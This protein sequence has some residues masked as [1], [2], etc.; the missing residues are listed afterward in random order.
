MNLSDD[1]RKSD[2]LLAHLCAK[3]MEPVTTEHPPVFTVEEARELRGQIDGVHTKNLFLRDAKRNYFLYVTDEDAIV[4]LQALAW[5]IGARGR[6]SFGSREALLELLGVQPGSVSLLAA[7]N[8]TAV[9]VTVVLDERILSGLVINCH[10]LTN[11]RT[12]SLS[13]E[14]AIAFLRSSGH[15]PIVVSLGADRAATQS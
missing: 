5:K 15:D 12:T 13:R 6:M 11:T 4:D 14:N 9:R 8:D 2:E 10:P 1:L 7:C 3:G